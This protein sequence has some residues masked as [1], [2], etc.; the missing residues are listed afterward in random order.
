MA[1]FEAVPNFSEG[2]DQALIE[3]LAADS[4]VIDVHAD[5]DHNRSVLTL[6]GADLTRLS[7]AL[8]AM[9]AQA[10]DR[11]DLRRHS[12]VHPRVG[13]A[14][15]VPI[16]PL[17]GAALADAVTA[18]KALGG[19][20]WRELGVPVY[21][22]ADA[23]GGRPL[24]DVR[25]GRV[26][27]DLG[28]THHPNAGAVCVGARLPLVAYNVAFS[29]LAMMRA[30]DIA[31]EMR[32]LPGVQALAF[33]LADGRTQISMN[34]IRPAQ[35]RVPDVYERA[36]QLARLGGE[37]EL[38]GLCPAAAAGPGCNG[39]LLEARIAA[40]AARVAAETARARPGEEMARLAQSLEA[41]SRSL[42][43]VPPVQ[44]EILTAA[45]RA[46]A[47]VRVLGAS[48]LSSA[49]LDAL[50]TLSAIGFRGAVTA[51]TAARFRRRV[52]LLDGWLRSAR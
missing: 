7:G 46:A 41:E 9:V 4:H 28:G 19:R 52:A 43:G 27:P 17:G 29:G 23:A 11:I 12:G 10:A 15:V 51:E 49:E 36:C 42:A 35:T 40:H 2:R 18:A 44:D 24:A 33:Q 25:S 26:E 6:V 8:F 37:P 16:V 21:F 34:L 32:K 38:V 20:I 1:V 39:A 47:L 14:D 3:R 13:A 5:P 50:L 31:A 45:E 22:Y 30:R 48:G